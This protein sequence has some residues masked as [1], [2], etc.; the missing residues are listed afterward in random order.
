MY[1]DIG[2]Q[3]II[4]IVYMHLVDTFN[5]TFGASHNKGFLEKY[6]NVMA[7]LVIVTLSNSLNNLTLPK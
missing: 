5:S 1:R 7:F 4:H 3:L 2:L 6:I